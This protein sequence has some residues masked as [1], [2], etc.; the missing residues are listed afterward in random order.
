M[1]NAFSTTYLAFE[2][3]CMIFMLSLCYHYWQIGE[4]AFE[5]VVSQFDKIVLIQYK[6]QIAL[7]YGTTIL[8]I[9]IL[10]IWLGFVNWSFLNLIFYFTLT[11]I[12]FIILWVFNYFMLVNDAKKNLKV[13]SNN[14]LY[15]FRKWSTTH[16]A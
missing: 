13:V 6:F 12:I 9:M 4:A 5:N 15:K 10:S 16:H 1:K 2:N 8:S 11:S 14:I 3:G 7:H